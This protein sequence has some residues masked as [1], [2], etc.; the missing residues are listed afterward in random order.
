[1]KPGVSLYLSL[2]LRLIANG[3]F[4]DVCSSSCGWGQELALGP[5]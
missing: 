3:C 2:L 5:R 4:A 1:V